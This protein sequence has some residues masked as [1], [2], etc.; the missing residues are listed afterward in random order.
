VVSDHAANR[1]ATP[2]ATVKPAEETRRRISVPLLIGLACIIPALL[3]GWQSY[4]Q[5]RLSAPPV[6][7]QWNNVAFRGAEWLFLGALT[8]I[9]YYLARRFPLRRETLRKTLIAHMVG[10]LVLCVGWAGAGIALQ[11]ALGM[12]SSDTSLSAHFVSWALT[13][14]PWSVFM[15]FAVLGTVYAFTYSIEAREREAQTARLAARLA[16]ARLS[17]LR[18]Q[19]NPHFLF[20]SLNALGVLVRAGRTTKAS[21]VI[22]LLGDVLRTVLRSDD[23][24]MIAL[25]DEVAFLEQ[26][27][28]IEHVRFSDRLV[29]TWMIDPKASVA[30]IPA[31]ILQPLVENALQ[32]GIARSTGAGRIEIGAHRENNLLV[33]TVADDGPGLG[34]PDANP[35]IDVRRGVG[36]AN[37]R[38][39]LRTIYGVEGTLDLTPAKHRGVVARITLPFQEAVDA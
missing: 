16:E 26:Y 7:I 4:M 15:Y 37:V 13:S 3:D 2:P 31:L 21:R 25:R 33:M 27:L 35:P 36:L 24:Q 20:N 38:E 9:T 17:A 29:V 18:A 12:V 30:V 34:Q 14:L 23:R 5:S 11:Y 39:R 22:E 28:A 19:L 6:R 1:Q 10:A 32:H 8:P